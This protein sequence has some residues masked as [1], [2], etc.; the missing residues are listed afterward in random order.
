LMEFNRLINAQVGK[1]ADWGGTSFQFNNIIRNNTFINAVPW[2]DDSSALLTYR[3]QKQY[4]TDGSFAADACSANYTIGQFTFEKNVVTFSSTPSFGLS[5]YYT[6]SW[7]AGLIDSLDNT[8]PSGTAFTAF[9]NSAN[10]DTSCSGRASGQDYTTVQWQAAGQDTTST[11]GA[12]GWDAY[13]RTNDGRGWRQS[14]EGGGSTPIA[15]NSARGRGKGR[16]RR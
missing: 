1:I 7:G 11:F 2:A 3:P 6:A 10:A 15:G 9:G 4:N 12:P 16:G 8:W 5:L 14:S 13:H